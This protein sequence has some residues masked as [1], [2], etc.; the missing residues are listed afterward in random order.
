MVMSFQ[1]L[2]L[3]ST[4]QY[5]ETGWGKWKR[6]VSVLKLVSSCYSGVWGG[7]SLFPFTTISFV[8]E[9]WSN[10]MKMLEWQILLKKWVFQVIQI[11]I[12]QNAVISSLD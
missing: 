6:M 5:T 11:P 10:E 1:P 9:S 8:S 7:L 2:T 4:E 12:P 3:L